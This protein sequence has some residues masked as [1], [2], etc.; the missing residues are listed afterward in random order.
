MDA[1]VQLIGRFRNFAQKPGPAL[2]CL[3]AGDEALSIRYGISV[4]PQPSFTAGIHRARQVTCS[5]YASWA[6][7]MHMIHLPLTDYFICPEDM[8]AT[9]DAG[10]ERAVQE[11]NRDGRVVWLTRQKVVAEA[12]VTGSIFV[13]IADAGNDLPGSSARGDSSPGETAK[14][15][16]Q[17]R[18]AAAG[19]VAEANG[20]N[21]HQQVEGE[22]PP[23]RFYLMQHANLPPLVFNSAA[24]FA[25]G[26]L[27]GVD[28]AQSTYPVEL[29]F[30]RYESDAA[31]N[32]WSAGG[33]ADDLRWQIVNTYPF[34][35]A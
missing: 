16:S 5:Q 32:D 27:E 28:L 30:I 35:Y 33:W 10:L 17:L 13:E 14:T 4:I 7:E 23:L 2:G 26:V 19:V 3:R 22:N 8:A 18:D 25:E 12:G 31:G 15:I 6:A 11:F 9:V 24:A 1:F 20:A 29:V 34:K 21:F